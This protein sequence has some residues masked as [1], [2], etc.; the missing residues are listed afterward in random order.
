MRRM[1]TFLLAASLAAMGTG[2]NILQIRSQLMPGPLDSPTFARNT[3]RNNV[4]PLPINPPL[5]IRWEAS[6]SAGIGGGSPIL[7]DTTVLIGNMRG[8]LLAFNLRTGKRMG[9]TALGGSIEGTPVIDHELAIVPLAGTSE[10]LIAYDYVNIRTR[11][12]ASFGDVQTSPLLLDERIFVGTTE[13][14]VFAVQHNSGDVLWRYDIPNNTTVKG[15]RSSPAGSGDHVVFGADDCTLYD[16]SAQSGTLRWKAAVDAPIQAGPSIADSTVFVGSIRGMLFAVRLSDG[17]IVWKRQLTG[18]IYAP[19]LIV[20][21]RCFV[22]TTSGTVFATDAATGAAIWATDLR[23]PVT[24]G[25]IATDTL[26]YVGTLGKE[27]VAL[28]QSGGTALWRTAT[29]GRIKTMPT[30]GGGRL[31][32]ATDDRSMLGFVGATP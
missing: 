32:V 8:E 24:A 10:S 18:G 21:G 23:A 26:L 30:A 11:W 5:T 12:R 14:G 17:R 13:G 15:I 25:L 2:C 6:V 16:L 19:P 29:P 9:S 28:G 27:L 1:G 20:S 7:I 4:Y 22:G 31:V 3:L